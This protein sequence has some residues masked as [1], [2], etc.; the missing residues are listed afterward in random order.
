MPTKGKRHY[1][2]YRR[3]ALNAAKDLLYDDDILTQIKNA[4]T[5][6]EIEQIMN[7]ARKTTVYKEVA[8]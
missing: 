4:S 8:L 6:N 3:F 2:D 1:S 7:K 5:E